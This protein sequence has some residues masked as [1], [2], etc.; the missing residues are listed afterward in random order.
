[1]LSPCLSEKILKAVLFSDVLSDQNQ[2]RVLVYINLYLI[3]NFDQYG[4]FRLP[5]QSYRI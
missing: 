3:H 2:L 1:M 4:D 5:S